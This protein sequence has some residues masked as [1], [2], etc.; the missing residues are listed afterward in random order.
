[1]WDGGS[2]NCSE[3]VPELALFFGVTSVETFWGPPGLGVL[4]LIGEL[5]CLKTLS[6]L[7]DIS[8]FEPLF[9][10]MLLLRAGEVC[11]DAFRTPQIVSKSLTHTAALLEVLPARF[12]AT[13]V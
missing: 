4:E 7:G 13:Q 3:A 10:I 9:S 8:N 6:L 11:E 12:S 2:L 5:D 1:M